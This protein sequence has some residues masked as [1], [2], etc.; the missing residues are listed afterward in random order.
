MNGDIINIILSILSFLLSAI[1]VITVVITL[2]QNNKMIEADTRPYVVAY[3]IYEEEAERIYFC[4]KNFGRSSAII[5]SLTVSPE[6]SINKST[7]GATFKDTLIAPNQQFHLVVPHSEKMR[8]VDKCIYEYK[9]AI[10]YKDC[11]TEKQYSEEN[12]INIG[13]I[14]D[15]AS[16]RLTHSSYTKTENSLYNI[17]KCIQYIKNSHL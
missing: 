15:V 9:V 11:T 16:A 13:Y 1:S 7:C 4:V 3:L 10:T 2:K 12:K 8:I 17:E 6:I 5:S 14:T